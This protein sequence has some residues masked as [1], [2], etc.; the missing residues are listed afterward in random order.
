MIINHIIHFT[1]TYFRYISG[2]KMFR[3]SLQMFFSVNLRK[4]R[5]LIQVLALANRHHQFNV[6]MKLAVL[7]LDIVNSS[8][9]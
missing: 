2:K 7:E 9:L 5:A 8:L 4:H 1:T 3:P 6:A